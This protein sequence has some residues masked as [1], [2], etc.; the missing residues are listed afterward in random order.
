[1][2]T[3]RKKAMTIAMAFMNR[4]PLYSLKPTTRYKRAVAGGGNLKLQSL[5]LLVYL[6][7]LLVKAT[8]YKQAASGKRNTKK[9]LSSL[10]P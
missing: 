7:N 9:S 8:R 10:T 3:G 2:H 6:Y 1:M 5:V 4:L